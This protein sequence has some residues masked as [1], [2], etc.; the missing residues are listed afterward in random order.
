MSYIYER[1][2]QIDDNEI[3]IDN[4]GLYCTLCAVIMVHYWHTVPAQRVNLD[5]TNYLSTDV[6]A[7]EKTRKLLA[8][9]HLASIVVVFFQ[10]KKCSFPY[11]FFNM[12]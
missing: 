4:D 12:L 2:L 3:K 10:R 6:V 8:T 5:R 7:L 9:Y 11:N 1:L